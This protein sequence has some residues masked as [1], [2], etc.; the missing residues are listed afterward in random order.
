M[1]TPISFVAV[2]FTAAWLS[3]ACTLLLVSSRSRTAQADD[4][5]GPVDISARGYIQNDFRF[6][7]GKPKLNGQAGGQWIRNEASI[8]GQLNLSLGDHVSG[9]A[10]M[11]PVLSLLSQPGTGQTQITKFEDLL[12]RNKLG[13][14]WFEFDNAYLAL[15]NLGVDGLELRLGQQVVVWGTGDFFNPTNNINPRDFYDPLQFGRPMG[16]QMAMLRYQGSLPISFQLIYIPVFRPA[17]L[18]PEALAGFTTDVLPLANAQDRTDL[19][20]L[21]EFQRSLSGFGTIT[22]T[23]EPY[24]VLPRAD[25]SQGNYAAKLGAALFDIDMSLSY[26]YGRWDLP[27]ANRVDPIVTLSPGAV[28]TLTR[29]QLIYPRMHVIGFDFSTSLDFLGGLGLWGEVAVF[30]PQGVNLRINHPDLL[31]LL[32]PT[33]PCDSARGCVVV[34]DQPFVKAT[35]GFDYSFTKHLYLNAQYLYGFVDEFGSDFVNHYA[36]VTSDIKPFGD[37]VFLRL[38]GVFNLN[39]GSVVAYP[40]LI[41]KLYT[42]VELQGGALLFLG[43][44]T[45]KFGKPEV[46]NSQVFVRARLSF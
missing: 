13:P 22:N 37:D 32:R 6:V 5:L 42:A 17:R 30:V 34:R 36:V 11:R 8:F 33:L 35:V 23:I 25:L 20:E 15:N 2:R 16:T 41:A 27:I 1:K 26:V 39:D 29:V 44:P 19:R 38:V 10:T 21:D 43:N 31:R 3:F 45:Q 7:V 9:V 24:P 12:D 46:G 40:V 28:D 18:P 14:L 4:T